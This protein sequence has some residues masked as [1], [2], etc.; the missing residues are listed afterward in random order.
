MFGEKDL[1][2]GSF[3]RT[4]EASKNPSCPQGDSMAD[5]VMGEVEIL[6]F[7]CMA[8]GRFNIPEVFSHPAHAGTGRSNLLS[9]ARSQAVTVLA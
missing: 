4:K 2:S 8:F 1:V 5:V 3:E 7:I 9:V 6:Y